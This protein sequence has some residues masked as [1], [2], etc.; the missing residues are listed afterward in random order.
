MDVANASRV[1]GQPLRYVS[2]RP[3]NEICL[4]NRDT[5]SNGLWRR[6]DSLYPQF[7]KGKLTG[8]K[9]DSGYDW[10]WRW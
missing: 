2:G 5:S 10:I 8:W 3:G 7:R 9:G 6:S 1:L 4:A